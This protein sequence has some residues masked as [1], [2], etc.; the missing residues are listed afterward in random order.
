MHIPWGSRALS[1]ALGDLHRARQKLVLDLR[2]P[3]HAEANIVIDLNEATGA[4][5]PWI[6]YD[7]PGDGNLDGVPD[8]NPGG[9]GTFGIYHGSDRLIYLREIY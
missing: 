7:W 3:P 8:D 2:N 5:L 1:A 4:G 6:Q 9:W